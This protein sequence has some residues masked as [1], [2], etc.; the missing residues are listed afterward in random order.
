MSQ[1]KILWVQDENEGPMNGLA[2]YNG[3]K[4]WFARMSNPSVISSTD[5]PVPYVSSEVEA[6]DEETENLA[7]RIYMLYRLSPNDML[8]VS[9]NH[10]EHCDKTGAP[11]NHG[12]PIKIKRKTKATKM[13]TEVIQSMVP[14]GKDEVEVKLERRSMAAVKQYDHKVVPSLVTGELVT[15]IKQSEFSNYLVPRT[16]VFDNF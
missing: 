8:S 10:I 12:D 1:A 13:P 2:E 15:T 16:C 14:E 6:E 9:L 7:D 3:E 4:L 5:V 11:L